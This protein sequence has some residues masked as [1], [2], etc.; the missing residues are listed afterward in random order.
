MM[1]ERWTY[2]SLGANQG[3]R[4][5]QLATALD[6]LRSWPAV[7][8]L[9]T[10]GVYETAAVECGP[11]PDYWNL[12]LRAVIEVHPEKLLAWTQDLESRAGRAPNSH[13][14]PRELDIDLLVHRQCRRSSELLTLPHSRMEDRRFVLEPLRDLDPQLRLPSG[15]PVEERLRSPEVAR[16]RLRRLGDVDLLW[17]LAGKGEA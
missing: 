1:G 4:G 8:Q 10:S 6:A 11:Q 2:L 12:C 3:D 5:G 17:A 14:A 15:V 9:E 16:Q 13:R 7:G